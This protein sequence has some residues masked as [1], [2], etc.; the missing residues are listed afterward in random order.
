MFRGSASGQVEAFDAYTG[1]RMWTFRT[2]ARGG[3]VRPGPS[4]TYEL[5]G[6]QFVTIAMGSEVW[7]FTLDGTVAARGEAVL[8]PWENYERPRP[9][10]R[11]TAVIETATNIESPT[12]NLALDVESFGMDE[13]RFNP[14]RALITAGVSVR[15]RNN[16]DVSHTIAARDGSWTAETVEPGMEVTVN[17]DG[18]GTFLYHCTEHPWAIGEMTVQE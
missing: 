18:R 6:R 17:L 12:P 9:A 5:S 15:F 1:V 13:H 4:A 2:S 14:V 10:P 3:R 11:E 7:G 8:D 16:G